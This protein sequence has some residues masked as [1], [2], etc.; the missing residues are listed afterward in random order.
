MKKLTITYISEDHVARRTY[1]WVRLSTEK[2]ERDCCYVR[3]R[4]G[5]EYDTGDKEP[6]MSLALFHKWEGK[7]GNKA[8]NEV[9]RTESTTSLSV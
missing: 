9:F 1:M 3:T 2:E 4:H 6:D 5:W 8:L 7:D